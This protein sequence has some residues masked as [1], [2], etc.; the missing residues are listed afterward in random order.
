MNVAIV[1]ETLQIEG[2][3]FSAVLSLK[4]Q[5]ILSIDF[6]VTNEFFLV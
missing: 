6:C 1:V 2:S 3:E 4:T 5:I